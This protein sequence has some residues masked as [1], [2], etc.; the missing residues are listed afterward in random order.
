MVEIT[1]LIDA[2]FNQTMR[3]GY[4]AGETY[5]DGVLFQSNQK[6]PEIDEK[7]KELLSKT[8]ASLKEDIGLY[9]DLKLEMC[10]RIIES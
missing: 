3:V 9:I 2:I 6:L 10:N 7:F 4:V 8:A 5:I 1:Q